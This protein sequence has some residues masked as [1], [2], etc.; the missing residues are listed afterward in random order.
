MRI[1]SPAS[2]QSAPSALRPVNRAIKLSRSMKS[3]RRHELQTNELAKQIA[4][5]PDTTR[6][7]GT[8]LALVV[9]LIA[10]VVFFF[11]YRSSSRKANE[12]AEAEVLQAITQ[13][14]INL[15]H[16]QHLDQ[17][18]DASGEASPVQ[19]MSNL[20]NQVAEIRKGLASLGESEN[21]KIRAKA[22]QVRGDLNLFLATSPEL[23]QAT[24]RPS[25]GFGDLRTGAMATAAESYQ[26]IIQTYGDQPLPVAGAHFGLAALAEDQGKWDDAR[27]EFQA[28]IDQPNLPASIAAQAKAR[29]DSIDQAMQPVYISTQP[30]DQTQSPESMLNDLAQKIAAQ[31][32]QP[33]ETPTTQSAT[34]LPAAVPAIPAAPATMPTT[35]PA[36]R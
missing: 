11:Y 34:T 21:T 14:V 3:E 30:A 26:S 12:A 17:A 10:V 36:A 23:P 1:L 4:K 16:Y 31:R 20:R 19:A 15:T 28:I 13:E 2:E 8:R 9:A 22:L 33:V 24:T 5:L 35:A 7:Y 6:Q 32:N 18:R 27:K 25:L 29:L